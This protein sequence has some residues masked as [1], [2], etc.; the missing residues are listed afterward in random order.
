[1]WHLK[2]ASLERERR[3]R[4]L[5][6]TIAETFPCSDPLSSIPDPRYTFDPAYA[7]EHGHGVAET[8]SSPEHRNKI[9]NAL[10]AVPRRIAS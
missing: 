2:E 8:D 3:E 1:M 6:E 7:V 10:P 4:A 5:D 9:E